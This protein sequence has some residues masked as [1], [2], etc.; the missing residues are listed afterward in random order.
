MQ[1]VLAVIRSKA[2]SRARSSRL[3]GSSPRL[4]TKPGT[5]TAWGRASAPTPVSSNVDLASWLNA[6]WWVSLK[7]THGTTKNEDQIIKT[8]EKYL[9]ESNKS[10][11]LVRPLTDFS[12]RCC[13]ADRKEEHLI[14]KEEDLQLSD[15]QWASTKQRMSSKECEPALDKIFHQE[16]SR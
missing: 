15:C 4:E 1:W 9:T 8:E 16:D 14:I 2:K 7:R 12:C 10:L 11:M 3:M 13:W 6:V 5:W